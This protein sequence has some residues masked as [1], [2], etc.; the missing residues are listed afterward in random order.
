MFNFSEIGNEKNE[1]NFDINNNNNNKNAIYHGMNMNANYLTSNNIIANNQNGGIN[2]N[3]FHEP[4]NM[5]TMSFMNS[6]NFAN[7]FMIDFKEN[8]NYSMNLVGAK[9]PSMG[10]RYAIRQ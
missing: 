7:Q 8:N 6:D 10:K 4:K 5:Q 3:E 2:G 1:K 9:F